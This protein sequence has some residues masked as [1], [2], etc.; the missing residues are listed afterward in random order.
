MNQCLNQ[1]KNTIDPENIINNYGA[2]AVRFFILSDSPPEKDIQWSE[3][4][5]ISSY[6]FVQKFWSL[7]KMIINLE[8]RDNVNQSK[9][10]DIF[11][12]QMIDKITK[13]LENFHYNV[14][15]ANLHEI[16][17]YLS[18]NL[19][20]IY[21]KEN[22]LSNYVKILKIIS[23]VM[24]HLTNECLDEL[25]AKERNKWPKVD[26][27]FLKKR[28]FDVVIQI[29]GKKR[30]LMNFNKDINE[31]DLL[32]EIKNNEKINKFLKDK[33]IKKS[34]YIKNKLINL[35]I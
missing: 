25:N 9:E 12:N 11:T 13:N 6:K 21:D 32:F 26:E 28:N 20:T 2:D 4:G 33:E 17:N 30:H 27:K 5:M 18:K 22:L 23:P 7:H 15:I 16:Y 10:V 34:I 3:Q 14:L 19:K 35:I 1:K 24:P 29:N 8:L 31:K